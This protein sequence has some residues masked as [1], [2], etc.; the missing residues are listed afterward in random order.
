MV[1]TNGNTLTVYVRGPGKL[2]LLAFQSNG[3]IPNHVGANSTTSQGVTRFIVSHSYTFERFAF[4]F[5][6]AGEA[7]YSVGPSLLR[8]PVGRSWTGATLV[9]WESPDITTADVSGQVSSAVVRDEKMAAF[10]VYDN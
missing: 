9:K 7:V 6:G 2:H 1:F 10:I 4:Y 5:E 3:R 8:Q